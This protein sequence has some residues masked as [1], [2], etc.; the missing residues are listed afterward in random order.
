MRLLI[1]LDKYFRLTISLPF[2]ALVIISMAIIKFIRPE[3]T[4]F[5]IGSDKEEDIT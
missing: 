2:I 5:T 1:W 3:K 4:T